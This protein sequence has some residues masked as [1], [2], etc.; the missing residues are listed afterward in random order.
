MSDEQHSPLKCP[1]CGYPVTSDTQTC[2]HC[3]VNLGLAAVL[4]ERM[5]TFTPPQVPSEGA[6]TTEA[7]V[8]RLGERLVRSGLI[9]P[10]QLNKA[11][12]YQREQE[13]KGTP[14]RLGQALVAL[15]FLDSETLD[16]V[17][18]EI[19]L[20]LQRALYQANARLEQEVA[21]RTRQLQEALRRLSELQ[22]LKANFV[23][24]ISHE[25]RTPL[26]HLVGYLDLIAEGALGALTPEQQH[27]VAVMQ[28]SATRLFRLIEDLISFALLSKGKL[29]VEVDVASVDA[30]LRDVVE[31]VEEDLNAKGVTFRQEVSSG[32]YV[33]ADQQKIYWVLHQLLDNAIKFTPSG[34]S[35]TLKAWKDDAKV[36][37]GVEDTGIGIPPE[38]LHLIFEPFVQLED[39]T[40]RHYGGTGLGLALV[41]QILEAHNTALKIE[42][43]P[44]VGTKVCFALPRAEKQKKNLAPAK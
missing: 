39:A 13:A 21:E 24:N 29:S 34:G 22:R 11:L 7:L 40:T 2:P 1:R 17:V 20:Q 9:T 18:A 5:V 16:R 42:S 31:S 33:L 30:M 26:T 37:F 36:Y 35:V 32:L 27:A 28:K 15:G 4:A 43:I 10:Q 23:A 12:A 41:K 6:M 25:L 19:I 38:H 8:P 14:I 3:G 44:K